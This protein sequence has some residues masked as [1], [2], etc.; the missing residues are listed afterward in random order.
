[1]VF[2]N[3]VDDPIVPE[4]LLTPIKEFAGKYFVK[5][6][7][8]FAT[9]HVERSVL[10]EILYFS[11]QTAQF[12]HRVGSRWP[13]GLLRGRPSLPQPDNLARSHSRLSRRLSDARRVGPRTQG[14]LDTTLKSAS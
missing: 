6:N 10:I 14:L 7:S 4:S 8:S 12:V 13:S 2:V 5:I 9:L 11:K 1:M 3:A